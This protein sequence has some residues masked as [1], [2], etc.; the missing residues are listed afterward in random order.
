MFWI[1][2]VIDFFVMMQVDV[3]YIIWYFCEVVQVF[4]VQCGMV[5]DDVEFLI[6]QFVGFVEY[7]E[8]NEGFV[9][10]VQ[11]VGQFGFFVGCIVYV[12]GVCQCYY[13]CV[14]GNGMQVGV[15]VGVF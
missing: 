15:F 13:Y 14:D 10:I 1:V 6:G 3:E 2:G 12:Q 11:V 5:L 7:V 8:W 4:I 9:Y